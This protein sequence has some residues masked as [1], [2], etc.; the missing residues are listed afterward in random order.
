MEVEYVGVSQI[1]DHFGPYRI[2]DDRACIC[3]DLAQ[4]LNMKVFKKLKYGKVN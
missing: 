1:M 3:E 4:S 2:D